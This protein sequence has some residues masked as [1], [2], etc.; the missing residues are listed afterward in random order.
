MLSP[1]GERP[2]HEARRHGIV[3]L[4]PCA[5]AMVLAGGGAFFLARGWPLSLAGALALTVAA[6]RV[7]HAV[8]GWERTRVVVT[9]ERLYVVDGLLRRRAAAVRL[10]R[11]GPIEI[12]QSLPGRLLGYGTVAAGDLEIAYVAEPAQLAELLHEV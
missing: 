2:R 10:A 8:L 6:L 11:V 4:R 1:V 9:S 5:G 3:L 7:V 12:E